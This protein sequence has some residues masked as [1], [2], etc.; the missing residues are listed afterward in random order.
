MP[1]PDRL[2]PADPAGRSVAGRCA[3]NYLLFRSTPVRHWMDYELETLPQAD[4][5]GMNPDA[6]LP[7][8][9]AR[10]GDKVHF[11]YLRNVTSLKGALQ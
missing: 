6:D 3:G 11:L 7:V 10:R 2:C 1:H 8:M 5:L 4:L 9:M